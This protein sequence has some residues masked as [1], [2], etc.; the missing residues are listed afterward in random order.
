M[1]FLFYLFLRLQLGMK[2]KLLTFVYLGHLFVVA[3]CAD[4]S[5][6]DVN[7]F[8]SKLQTAL[9]LTKSKRVVSKVVSQE[10]KKDQKDGMLSLDFDKQ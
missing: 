6:E 1:F 9:D 4:E 10:D 7:D 5:T 3:H 8:E 2:F